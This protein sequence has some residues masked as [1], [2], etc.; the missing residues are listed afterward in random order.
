M[1]AAKTLFKGGAAVLVVGLLA[2]MIPAYVSTDPDV[3]SIASSVLLVVLVVA[4]LLFVT[5]GIVWAATRGKRPQ[6]D[7]R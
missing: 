4:V 7:I 5:G 2:T 6:G 1:D 3:A